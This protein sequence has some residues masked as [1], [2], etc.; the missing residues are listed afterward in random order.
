MSLPCSPKSA[1]VVVSV[2]VAIVIGIV[3]VI[4]VPL[5]RRVRY[6]LATEPL[7]LRLNL[8]VSSVS[9]VQ[10]VQFSQ[11]VSHHDGTRRRI[12]RHDPR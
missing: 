5:Y 6:F 7:I 10:S 1:V 11:S 12:W 2:V 9:S 3:I 4:V 8:S